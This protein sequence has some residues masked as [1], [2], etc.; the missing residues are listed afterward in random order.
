MLPTIS[1]A[2]LQP[3]DVLLYTGTGFFGW[4]TRTKT[5]SPV[6]HVEIYAGKG[7]TVTASVQ[8]GVN[9][10][11]L[12]CPH[13][14]LLYVRRP[15]TPFD[16]VAATE[17]FLN[18]PRGQDYDSFGLFRAFFLRKPGAKNKMWCSEISDLYLRAGKVE[19]FDNQH[20]NPETIAPAQFLQTNDL[21]D[22][23]GAGS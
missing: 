19:L 11:P 16:L 4:L 10:H 13:K 7:K 22:I 6:G 8:F 14:K 20:A 18:G 21:T 15:K 3:G 17:W 5:W 12:R 23:W 9:F 1:E 2:D